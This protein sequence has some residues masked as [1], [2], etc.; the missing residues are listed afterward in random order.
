[1]SRGAVCPDE[2]PHGTSTSNALH[3]E[4]PHADPPDGTADRAS[5]P[6]VQK[7]AA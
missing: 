4:L 2:P 3:H 7:G 5:A 1:M 6:D